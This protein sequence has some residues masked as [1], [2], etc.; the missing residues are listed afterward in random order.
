MR[1]NTGILAGVMMR[2]PEYGDIDGNHFIQSEEEFDFHQEL[3]QL[4]VRAAK[5]KVTASTMIG[6]LEA[7][8]FLILQRLSEEEK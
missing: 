8:K 5:K 4:L 7:S 3:F 6:G 1:A 2:K